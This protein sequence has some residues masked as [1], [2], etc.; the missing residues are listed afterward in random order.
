MET[1]T[2][3]TIHFLIM[4]S[5]KYTITPVDAA[6]DFPSRVVHYAVDQSV[7]RGSIRK[8]KYNFWFSAS[9]RITPMKDLARK[10][11]TIFIVS[12]RNNVNLSKT[13]INLFKHTG[14]VHQRV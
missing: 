12:F 10:T 14:F 7:P 6:I 11:L 4:T 13:A 3:Y 9:L 2:D 8:T 5:L 1:T